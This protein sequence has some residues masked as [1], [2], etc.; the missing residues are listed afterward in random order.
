MGGRRG[1]GVDRM[2]RYNAVH[3]AVLVF[4]SIFFLREGGGGGGG[5][6][7]GGAGLASKQWIGQRKQ[8]RRLLWVLMK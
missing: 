1:V 8:K 7:P 2:I 3:A 5:G 4:W 6:R